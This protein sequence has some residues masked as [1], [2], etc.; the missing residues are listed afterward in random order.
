MSCQ[1]PSGGLTLLML[2]GTGTLDIFNRNRKNVTDEK[3][4]GY[5]TGRGEWRVLNFREIENLGKD[6]EPSFCWLWCTVEGE[7]GYWCSFELE[8]VSKQI[9]RCTDLWNMPAAL[10][11]VYRP[12]RNRFWQC[13]MF[14]QERPGQW[15]RNHLTTY[16]ENGES[17]WRSKAL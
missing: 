7:R 15:G 8:C 12:F 1:K 5:F 17:P 6:C 9:Q 13:E 16:K 2:I 11:V 14:S 4:F 3:Y 10:C